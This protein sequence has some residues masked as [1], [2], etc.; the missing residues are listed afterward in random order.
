MPSLPLIA[1][2]MG[3]GFYHLGRAALC[4]GPDVVVSGR[5]LLRSAVLSQLL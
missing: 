5:L 3:L 4:A 1:V 2:C